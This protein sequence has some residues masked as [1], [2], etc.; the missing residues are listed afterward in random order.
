MRGDLVCSRFLCAASGT[1]ID[2]HELPALNVELFFLPDDPL[3]EALATER[4]ALGFL[5]GSGFSE[6]QQVTHRAGA[7]P[8]IDARRSVARIWG[9]HDLIVRCVPVLP[10]G[11]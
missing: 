5:A 2:G 3:V 1:L 4:L 8:V 10:V 7:N 6:R 11:C 9:I